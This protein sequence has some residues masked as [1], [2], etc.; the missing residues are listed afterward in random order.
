M[1]GFDSRGLANSIEGVI[2]KTMNSQTGHVVRDTEILANS[3][4]P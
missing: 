2:M 3:Q 1:L 4:L